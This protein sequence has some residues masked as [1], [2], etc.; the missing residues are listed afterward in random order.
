MDDLSWT[1]NGCNLLLSCTEVSRPGCPQLSLNRLIWLAFLWY[2]I[3]IQSAPLSYGVNPRRSSLGVVSKSHSF[4]YFILLML[5]C[6]WWKHN[7]CHTKY[8]ERKNSM[9]TVWS[10]RLGFFL[11]FVENFALCFIFFL[12]LSPVTA[13]YSSFVWHLLSKYQFAEVE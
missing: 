11:N 3:W 13:T 7:S 5:R 12:S 10:R 9:L 6:R 4:I 8:M 1:T 2:A